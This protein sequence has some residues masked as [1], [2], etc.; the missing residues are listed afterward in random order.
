MAQCSSYIPSCVPGRANKAPVR[1]RMLVGRAAHKMPPP[2]LSFCY[3]PSIIKGHPTLPHDLL[4]V[5]HKLLSF[6][7]SFFPQQ[8]YT[9]TLEIARTKIAGKHLKK[10]LVPNYTIFTPPTPLFVEKLLVSWG[11]RPLVS[12]PY[13][14][15]SPVY[16]SVEQTR[17]Y[18]TPTTFPHV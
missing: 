11:Q 1:R 17:Y 5:S 14:T 6:P 13:P 8:F 7:H 12:L 10:L 15:H 4:A 16:F 18:I 2:S 3:L 9:N